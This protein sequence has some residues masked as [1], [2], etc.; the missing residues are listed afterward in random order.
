V[1]IKPAI[2]DTVL[3][4]W[5]FSHMS[6][7]ESSIKKKMGIDHWWNDDTLSQILHGLTQN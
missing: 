6:F 5:G 1:S 3:T 2:A 4:Y 7:D